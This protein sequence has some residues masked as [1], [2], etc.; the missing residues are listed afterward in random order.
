[1]TADPIHELETRPE[2]RRAAESALRKVK[3]GGVV[4]VDPDTLEWREGNGPDATLCFARIGS[5]K[6]ADG[7]FDVCVRYAGAGTE[8][9]GVGLCWQHGG[10][11][12]DGIREAAWIVGHAFARALEVTPW[13]GLLLAVKIAAGRSAF[14]ESKLATAT[15]DEDLMPNG[16][17]WHWVKQAELWHEK[18]AKVSKLAID[19]GVAERLVRQ[20]ELEATLML[21]ATRL[22]LAEL[23]LS[24]DQQE[25]A[26]GIMSRN[27]LALE[28]E[29]VG[30]EVVRSEDAL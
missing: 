16:D 11:D 23:G 3:F 12:E 30:V 13:E 19:A 25:H 24:D 27:L 29:E 10:S 21:K 26:I 4:P 7:R 17:L 1:M 6:R 14:C 8:H 5:R 20:L 2:L 9:K 18:M 15:C 22:T 28:A